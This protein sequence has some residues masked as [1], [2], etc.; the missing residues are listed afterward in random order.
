MEQGTTPEDLARRA[1]DGDR[2]ALDGLVR[3]LQGDIYG[4]ALRMLWNRQDA[5][6]ATQEILIRV[7]TRL[8]QFDFRSKLKTWGLPGRRQLHSR[9]EEE[10]G[11]ADESELRAVRRGPCCRTVRRWAGRRRAVA[12]RRGGEDRVH[13]RHAPMPGSAASSRL[14]PRR[15]PG[16]GS[17]IVHA[18]LLR[19]G[20]RHGGVRLQP[21]RAH[22]AASRKNPRGWFR[23]R[24]YGFV[25]SG[26]P[27][28]CPPRGRGEMGTRGAPNQSSP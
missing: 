22:S 20:V 6:D 2:E 14:R 10:P 24:T 11:R 4:L 27:R 5:E 26:S 19:A 21:S 9:C 25:V 16:D 12:P 1:I 15:D 17:L 13:A 7:V 23:L 8:S 18:F 3:A 28:D